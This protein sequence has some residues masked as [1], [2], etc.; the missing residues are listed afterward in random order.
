M[1]ELTCPVCGAEII[2][3]AIFCDDCGS[4]LRMAGAVNPNSTIQ[5]VAIP[6]ASKPPAGS[7]GAEMLADSYPCPNCGHSNRPGAAFCEA[8]GTAQTRTAPSPQGAL[9]A[10]QPPIPSAATPTASLTLRDTGVKLKF[11][12]DAREIVVGRADDISGA[13]PEIDLEPYGAQD[14]GVS[15]RHVRISYSEGAWKVEDL[16]SVNGTRLNRNRLP[17]ARETVLNS[18]DELRLGNLDLIFTMD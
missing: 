5:A 2:P 8:C 4:D 1:A 14:A 12:P 9:P 6:L 17:P 3:G 18:G 11:P 13:F 10:Y 15:R 16:S 7:G